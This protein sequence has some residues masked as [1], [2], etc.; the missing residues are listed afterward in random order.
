M[1]GDDYRLVVTGHSLGGALTNICA[2]YA[3]REERFTKNGPIQGIM[4]GC[5]KMAGYQLVDAMRFQEDTHK[6]QIA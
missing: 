3:S 4:F 1:I 5:P 6:L 2:L